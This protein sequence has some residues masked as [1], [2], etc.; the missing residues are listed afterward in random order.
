MLFDVCVG[1]DN[2]VRHQNQIRRRYCSKAI[3]PESLT[4]LSLDILLDTFAI[5]TDHPVSEPN[6]EP[7]SNVTL[8]VSVAGSAPSERKLPPRHRTNRVRRTTQPIQPRQKRY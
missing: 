6:A 7:P 5:L 4:S 2:W 1:N 3:E 8:S